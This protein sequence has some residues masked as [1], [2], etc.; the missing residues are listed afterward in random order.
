[1]TFNFGDDGTGLRLDQISVSPTSGPA[2]ESADG[3]ITFSDPETADTHTASFVPQGGDYVG[4][5]SL[6]P[7]SES[8]GSGSVGWHFTVNN[9]DIQFLAQDQV[10]SQTYTVFVTDDHGASTAQDVT[11]SMIGTND[12]PTAVG[13]TVITNVGANGTVDIPL[14]ALAANE[15]IRTRQT[16]TPRMP[17]S[18]ARA[19]PRHCPAMPPSST[20]RRREVHSTTP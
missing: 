15:S 18:R 13:E 11:V 19:D 9:S 20:M 6:D 2:T 5:F 8:G 14:W 3:S 17:S 1:M 16:L 12:A 4:T 10:L 7:L